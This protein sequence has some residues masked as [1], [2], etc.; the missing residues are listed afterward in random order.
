MEQAGWQLWAKRVIDRVAGATALVAALPVLAGTAAAIRITMGGPVL[1][2]Q[3]RGGHRGSTFEVVKFRTMRDATGPDGAP[4]PDEDRL[5][6]LGRFLRATSLDEL[7]QL[8]NVVRGELSLVGPRPLVARY[9]TRYTPA[10]A[11]RHDVIP[12]MTGWAQ[13]NGR[14]AHDWP[15]KFRL[16]LWYVE[17]WSL[18]L[19]LQILV[20]TV[21]EVVRPSGVSNAG[22]A[23]MPEFW[24]EA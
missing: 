5:T 10:Q 22:H 20:R 13:V 12:G 6:A 24:G 11:R 7:P 16:D 1:F 2:R 8:L 19:D 15:S 23:T 3:Q 17:H 14:N 21:R 18:W 9:L 4:L